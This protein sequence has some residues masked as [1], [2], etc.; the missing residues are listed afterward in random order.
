MTGCVGTWHGCDLEVVGQPAHAYVE[1]D[2]TMRDTLAIVSSRNLSSAASR[3]PRPLP[4]ELPPPTTLAPR[5]WVDPSGADAAHGGWRRRRRRRR[6]RR[7][8]TV[9]EARRQLALEQAQ[10]G[11]GATGLGPRVL[12][13]GPPDSGR[14]TVVRTLVAY[15]T[16][17]PCVLP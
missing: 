2:T 1:T 13:V 8:H 11:G 12:V 5:H 16:R 17:G 4:W 10:A 15:A 7:Q 14:S 3:R 9:L 6:R